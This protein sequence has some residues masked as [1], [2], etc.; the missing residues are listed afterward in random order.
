MIKEYIVIRFAF[1]STCLKIVVCSVVI[2]FFKILVSFFWKGNKE[3]WVVV[4]VLNYKTSCKDNSVH[5]NDKWTAWYS[6]L[7]LKFNFTLAVLQLETVILH[8]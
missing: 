4:A 1:N 8:F 3:L 5:Q 6:V 7:F 2:F